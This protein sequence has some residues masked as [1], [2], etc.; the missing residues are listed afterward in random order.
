L[1]YDWKMLHVILS[2]ANIVVEEW[3]AFSLERARA[4]VHWNR[5]QN[6]K[7]EV[8]ARL[9]I[10][11]ASNKELEVLEWVLS[12]TKRLRVGWRV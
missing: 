9:R 12:F 6:K 7:E 11:S 2:P 10:A 8:E 4:E 5:E 1:E 3:F